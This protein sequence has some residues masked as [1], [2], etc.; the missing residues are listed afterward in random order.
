[1]QWLV[2][3]LT[4]SLMFMAPGYGNAQQSAGQK[5]SPAG[6]SY[7]LSERQAYQ[8]QV[9]QDLAKLQQTI[10]DLRGRYLTSSP[11]MKRT[12]L[13]V[14]H[15]LDTQLLDARNKLASLEKASGADWVSLKGGM[16]KALEDL[17]KACKDAESRLQ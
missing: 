12:T 6:K 8:K 16:D 4:A 2:I 7:T 15:G 1:M 9:G 10:E 17:A 14:L 5:A 13:R 11:Q 3:L